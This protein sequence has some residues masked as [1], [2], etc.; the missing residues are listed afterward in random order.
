MAELRRKTAARIQEICSGVEGVFGVVVEDLTGEERFAVN[1]SLEFPQA[2]AI[3]VPVLMELYKQAHEGRLDL[4]ESVAVK[5]DD[6]VPGGILTHAGDGTTSMSLADLG[7]YMIVLSDNTAT[8]LLINKVGM[9]NINATLDN[10]GLP[11]TRVQRLMIDTEA[12]ARGQENL[13]TPAEAARLL[14]MLHEGEFVDRAVSDQVLEVMR[15]THG[16]AVKSALPEGVRVAFKPGEIPGVETEWAIVELKHRPYVVAAM[17][18]YGV[19]NGFY[20]A[21]QD[22]SKAAYSYFDRLGRSSPY[23]AYTDS[24]DWD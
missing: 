2:S 24:E 3:K 1:A 9:A 14:R 4:S 10:L 13:S 18:K 8:N 17:G 19:G 23:G 6:Q 7:V 22:I 12:S 21:M 5:A 15:K 16:G 11:K 20:K